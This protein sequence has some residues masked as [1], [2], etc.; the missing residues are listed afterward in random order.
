MLYDTIR[1]TEYCTEYSD[2]DFHFLGA[3]EFRADEADSF[4]TDYLFPDH[5]DEA[6]RSAGPAC[7]M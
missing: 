6:K 5:M 4:I 1:S 2:E 7:R 3:R